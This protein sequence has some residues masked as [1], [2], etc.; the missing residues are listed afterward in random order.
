MSEFKVWAPRAKGVE[1]ET[2]GQ[3]MDM[4]ESG[5]G[6]WKLDV[7]SAGPG[8][9]YA[10]RLDG[11]PPMPDPRS[12]WQPHGPMKPSRTVDHGEF[13]W[14]DRHWQSRPLS[15]AV[16]YEVHTGTFT[17]EGTFEDIIGKLDH[18]YDLGVTHL[19]LLP[20]AEFDGT[21]GWGYDGV[22]LFAPFHVY[23]GPTG[24]KKLVDACH[25]KGL[26]VV[27][28]V[29][30]NHFGPSGCFLGQ[31]GPYFTDRHQT[32]WGDAVNFDGTDSDEVR[33]FVV[34]NALMWLRDYHID[35]L[36]LD[37]IHAIL[38][39]SAVHILEELDDE[40]HELSTQ[41]GR[42][43]FLIAESDLNNPRVVQSR[44]IGGYGMDAQWNDDFHHALHVA[45]TGERAGYYADFGGLG[46]V[47]Q[48]L[49]HA[50]LYD[51]RCSKYRGRRHGRPVAGLSGHKF[52]GYM[53]NHDQIGNRARGDRITHLVSTDRA[54][55]GAALMLV[56]PF[57]P[58]IFQGEEWAASAPFQYFTGFEDAE[59]GRAV[60]EG[61]RSEF[62]SFG[63]KPEDV[64]DPQSPETFER[65]KLNWGELG[66]EPH[67]A[68][69]QWYRD[70][71]RLR[72]R[73]GDLANGHMNT[74]AADTDEQSGLLTVRRGRFGIMFNFGS[75]AVAAR[76]DSDIDRSV[77][78][79]SKPE[80]LVDGDA[81]QLPAE[82]V[83]IIGP[84]E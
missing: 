33:R 77:V 71:I 18:I 82:S 68:M 32:P 20:V 12:P 83:A 55:L 14:T 65:S 10:F 19:E 40:V 51:G 52:L 34:D 45:L 74:V 15:S 3:R 48:I 56:S 23:G 31:F 47:P 26:G 41:L 80:I 67:A 29:V 17:P 6:W 81:V 46:D 54:R 70:L 25:R 28:D 1:L 24:L 27:L 8:T 75:R 42:H 76:L 22:D 30:Y 4:R 50:F 44:E 57:V 58:M 53:Q 61:R 60:S 38:D 63:W 69:L 43:L 72:H 2:D 7:A 35:G 49:R 39:T 66:R 16:I 84:P 64:P 78:V 9:D 21:R 79:K 13:E 11:G 59:L 62:G 73:F 37:G 36:R 5:G